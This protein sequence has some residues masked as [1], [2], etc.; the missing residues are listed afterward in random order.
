MVKLQEVED[1]HF[2]QD[3][4]GPSSKPSLPKDVLLADEDDDDMAYSDTGQ[5]FSIASISFNYASSI[6]LSGMISTIFLM[7]C[8][9]PSCPLRH[10]YRYLRSTIHLLPSTTPLRA[11]PYQEAL[12]PLLP[13]PSSIQTHKDHPAK[14]RPSPC[15]PLSSYLLDHTP[16]LRFFN[17]I[18]LRRRRH[19][20]CRRR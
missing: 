18:L 15:L 9:K 4:P 5:S 8:T 12:Q 20:P 10:P 19:S 7:R 14:A 16:N 13:V 2:A 17:N 1:E 3:Q 11:I 6:Y